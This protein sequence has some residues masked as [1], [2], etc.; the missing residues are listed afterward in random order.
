MNFLWKS[1]R[2]GTYWTK[3]RYG[4]SRLTAKTI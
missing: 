3:C 2:E 4:D 1:I